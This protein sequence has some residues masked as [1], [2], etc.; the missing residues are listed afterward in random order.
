M[1]SFWYPRG[2]Q[3]LHIGRIL[4]VKRSTPS[5]GC[6]ELS[7]MLL[8]VFVLLLVVP[9]RDTAASGNGRQF[10]RDILCPA[11]SRIV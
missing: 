9:I 6:G 7:F 2:Y 4:H 10:R 5:V 11:M 1:R 8:L 3:I